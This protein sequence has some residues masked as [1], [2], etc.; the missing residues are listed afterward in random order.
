M[1]TYTEK[2]EKEGGYLNEQPFI[3]IKAAHKPEY[4][5]IVCKNV[6]HLQRK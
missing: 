2:N 4:T 3:N 1:I 5:S 6:I